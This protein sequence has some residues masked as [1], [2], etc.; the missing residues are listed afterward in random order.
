[1]AV[2]QR[3]SPVVILAVAQEVAVIKNK[4]KIARERQEVKKVPYPGIIAGYTAWQQIVAAHGS[5][6]ITPSQPLHSLAS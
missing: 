2:D 3:V 5:R 4:G 6:T 1:M